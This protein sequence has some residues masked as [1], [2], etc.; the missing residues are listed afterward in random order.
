MIDLVVLV[1]QLQIFHV[2]SLY[3]TLSYSVVSGDAAHTNFHVFGVSA[4]CTQW[5]HATTNASMQVNQV[6]SSIQIECINGEHNVLNI[7]L[8]TIRLLLVIKF[9]LIA[10]IFSHRGILQVI[11]F[12]VMS[13][14]Q[15]FIKVKD[16]R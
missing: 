14:F 6:R 3:K 2:F 8:N 5:G 13:P 10:K 9:S 1:V 7:L 4:F 11:F 12:M 15:N 16:I